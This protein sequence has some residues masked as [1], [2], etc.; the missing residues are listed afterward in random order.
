MF[1]KNATGLEKETTALV[2]VMTKSAM[3]GGLIYSTSA[4]EEKIVCVVAADIEVGGA[5]YVGPTRDHEIAM[6]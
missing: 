1:A 3:I 4:V 2:A 5:E 6:I